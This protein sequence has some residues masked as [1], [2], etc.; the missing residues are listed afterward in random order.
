M[1]NTIQNPLEM[2][3]ENPRGSVNPL[4]IPLESQIM[5]ENTTENP[6]ENA[7]RNPRFLRCRLLVCYIL[8]LAGPLHLRRDLRG[9][10]CGLQGFQG[11]GFHRSTNHFEILREIDGVR[12]VV[13]FVSSNWG[14]LA[15]SLDK[16]YAQS[17]Y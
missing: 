15:V 5:L 4:E 16:Q 1:E 14:P 9:A 12:L 7:A 10:V 13:F 3:S 2:S 6:L 17:P 8:P 11:Y